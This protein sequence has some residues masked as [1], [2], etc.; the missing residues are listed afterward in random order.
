MSPLAKILTS[1]LLANFYAF[2]YGAVTNDDFM[3]HCPS[4][5]LT[6][7]GYLEYDP[8]FAILDGMRR[9]L[10]RRAPQQLYP[11]QVSQPLG[12][13]RTLPGGCHQG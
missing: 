5:S 9:L 1:L 10:T 13:G 12:V 7:T 3:N 8:A 2:C 4:A 6:Q 11:L